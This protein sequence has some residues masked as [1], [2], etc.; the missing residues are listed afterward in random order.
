M[1]LLNKKNVELVSLMGLQAFCEKVQDENHKLTGKD[2]CMA[3]MAVT[4]IGKIND[5]P[6]SEIFAVMQNDLND[7]IEPEEMFKGVEEDDQVPI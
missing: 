3:I 6:A 7:N 4:M 5:V 2:V 1:N